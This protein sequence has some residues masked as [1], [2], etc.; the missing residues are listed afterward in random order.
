MRDH[1]ARQ[2]IKPDNIA[3]TITC[4][5][6]VSVSCDADVPA[7]DINT[8]SASDNCPGVAISHVG[9]TDNGGNG[10]PGNATVITRTYQATDASGNTTNCTQTIT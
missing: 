8:A 1:K 2:G 7:V 5:A 9:D 4:P 6:A 3:P 10:C